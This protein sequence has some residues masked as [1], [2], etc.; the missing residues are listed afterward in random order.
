M[1]LIEREAAAK[2]GSER[3]AAYRHL[4]RTSGLSRSSDFPV[5][6]ANSDDAHFWV[7]P[8]AGRTS[9]MR[10]KAD[11]EPYVRFVVVS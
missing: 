2:M 10:R 1:S 3:L 7:T 6:S 5:I 8:K 4:T 11:S 9:G